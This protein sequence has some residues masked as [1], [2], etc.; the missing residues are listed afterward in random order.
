M[1]YK[2]VSTVCKTGGRGCESVGMNY[3]FVG[4]DWINNGSVYKC[5]L[6]DWKSVSTVYKFVGGIC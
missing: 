1:G 4:M 2:P 3:E 6:T 5:E